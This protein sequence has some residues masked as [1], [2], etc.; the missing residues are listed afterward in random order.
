[1]ILKKIYLCS[2]VGFENT[3]KKNVAFNKHN[4]KTPTP[5]IQEP[6]ICGEG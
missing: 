5:P 1:M 4:N 6:N 3:S 2:L